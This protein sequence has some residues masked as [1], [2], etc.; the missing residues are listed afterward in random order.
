M[1]SRHE[2][3]LYKWT[4]WPFFYQA[5]HL[6][7]GSV[8]KMREMSKTFREELLVHPDVAVQVR[9]TRCSGLRGGEES[10]QEVLLL[11]CGDQQSTAEKTSRRDIKEGRRKDQC[12]SWGRKTQRDTG[13]HSHCWAAGER[14][15]QGRL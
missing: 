3:L 14:Q 10:E 5:L 12:M 7:A 4:Y 6:V 1:F 9:L 15:M 13:G 8:G 2:T 11:L